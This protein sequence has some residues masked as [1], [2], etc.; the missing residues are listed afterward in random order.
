[1]LFREVNFMDK[2][3]KRLVMRT[4]ILILLVGAIG[5]VVYSTATKEKTSVLQVGDQAP[6]FSLVDLEG[7]KHMLS[8]YEGQGVF[9]NFWGTWCKP[10]EK[11]MPYMNNQYAQYKDQG[12]EILAINI[13]QSDFEVQKFVDQYGLDFPVVIDKTKG[14]RNAYNIIGLPATILVSPEGKV[15]K[16]VTGELTEQ[17]IGAM[18]ESIKPQ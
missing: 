10:C 14:V 16:I 3:K 9:L 17:Q 12:V 4:I 8:D 13:A 2:K 6:N 7:N 11:E 1:M 15:T 18:M 5:Y